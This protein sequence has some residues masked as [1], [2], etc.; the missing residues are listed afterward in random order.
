MKAITRL[1]L[2]QE[3]YRYTSTTSYNEVANLIERLLSSEVESQL[4]N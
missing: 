1:Q 3:G 2:P 4:E